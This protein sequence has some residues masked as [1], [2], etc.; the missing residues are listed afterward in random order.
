MLV[1]GR[2]FDGRFAAVM[3][4]WEFAMGEH[5]FRVLLGDIELV[6]V[7]CQKCHATVE[8]KLDELAATFKCSKCLACAEPL[9]LRDGSCE[10]GE[11]QGALLALRA[12]A[13][14]LTVE[15]PIV[16]PKE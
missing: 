12:A 1:Q 5:V 9:T 4:L 10:L 14:T 11:L 8:V 16:L 15:F 7:T 2:G 3:S 6:R 13:K